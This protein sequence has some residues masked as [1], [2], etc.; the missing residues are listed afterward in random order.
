M[1]AAPK[2]CLSCFPTTG[3][4]HDS[5]YSKHYSLSIV[6]PAFSNRYI[7]V[8]PS[9]G[10]CPDSSYGPNPQ[11]WPPITSLK[12]ATL[13]HRPGQPNRRPNAVVNHTTFISHCANP[14]DQFSASHQRCSN[15]R[16]TRLLL[17]GHPEPTQLDVV[18]SSHI[19]LYCLTRKTPHNSNSFGPHAHARSANSHPVTRIRVRSRQPPSRCLR[20]P[21]QCSPRRISWP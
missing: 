20:A 10:A 2:L 11:I 21:R 8:C 19:Q 17:V 6:S 3:F 5:S 1:Q 16:T 18:L 12:C 15:K 14:S 13:S 9:P 7:S 4:S